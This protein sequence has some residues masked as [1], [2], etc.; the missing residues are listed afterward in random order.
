MKDTIKFI[1]IRTIFSSS[2]DSSLF[3]LK[4]GDGLGWGRCF[5]IG[6]QWRQGSC[7]IDSVIVLIEA[8]KQ[9]PTSLMVEIGTK[10]RAAA[11]HDNNKLES[12]IDNDS[13]IK[14]KEQVM[15]RKGTHQRICSMETARH[16][17]HL[18]KKHFLG[19]LFL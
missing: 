4:K 1:Q 12:N 2:L 5:M 17:L 8:R 19:L 15:S 18:Q 14:E 6:N 16:R 9:K 7:K 10:L 13:P 3:S 11:R